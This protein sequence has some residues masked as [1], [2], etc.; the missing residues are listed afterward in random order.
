MSIVNNTYFANE[1]FLP[2][3]KP[4]ISDDVTAIDA[5]ITAFI[6]TYEEE[7]LVRCLGYALY[8]LFVAQLDS[9]QPNGLIVGA[10]AKWDE[11]LNGTEFTDSE[12]ELVKWK[13]IRYKTGSVYNKSFIADYIYYQYEKSVD[14]SRV[15]VGNVKEQAAN[16][17]M[18][19]KA[20]KVVAAWRRF[21]KAVKGTEN[22][23]IF[24]DSVLGYGIDWKGKT[25]DV[26]LYSF[27]TK[28]NEDDPLT[29]P[30]YR[31][32]NF[33]NMNQFGI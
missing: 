17:E 2:H 31:P 6:E 33:T 10:A 15:G 25:N 3:A 20:P 7:V 21:I 8:K 5:D 9:N 30:N 22:T 1:I 23:P 14:D 19:S 24:I 27:I 26:T 18:V 29:Y 16:A 4:S 28:K 12:G 13:G 11:L 32:E